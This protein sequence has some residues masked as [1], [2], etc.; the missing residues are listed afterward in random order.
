MDR[1]EVSA[2]IGV[3]LDQLPEDAGGHQ[4]RR[5]ARL[6][7]SPGVRERRAIWKD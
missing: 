6:V 2:G 1:V 7:P 3:E 5:A 4:P